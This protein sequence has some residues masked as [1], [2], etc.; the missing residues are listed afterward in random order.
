M[1]GN[2]LQF[3]RSFPTGGDSLTR[4][5]QSETG[6]DFGSAERNKI[7]NA[8]LNGRAQSATPIYVWAKEFITELKRSIGAASRELDLTASELVREIWLCGGGCPNLR[9]FHLR[10]CSTTNSRTSMEPTRRTEVFNPQ[11]ILGKSG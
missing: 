10:R 2:V 7:G 4:Y 1:R 9:L 6:D 11:S 8:E 3:S 5:Y